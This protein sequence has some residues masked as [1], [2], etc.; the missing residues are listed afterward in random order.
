[1][2][3]ILVTNDFPPKT[4]GIQSYLW[5][6]W[7]R[8]PTDS[9]VVLT[10]RGPDRGAAAAKF[11][12]KEQYRIVRTD[13]A[14]LLPTP[15]LRRRINE[16]VKETAAVLVI[17][18]PV[19]PLGALG[20]G[21]GLDVPYGLVVHGA[22]TTMPGRF[23][24]SRHLMG[25]VLAGAKLVIAAGP[26]PA[27]QAQNAV[28]DH[29]LDT[30]VIPPGVDTAKFRPLVGEERDEARARFG[31]PEEARLV[32]SLSRLVPRKGMD[33]LIETSAELAK[34]RDDLVVAIGG[35]GRDRKRLEGLIQSFDA[36]V[37]LVGRVADEDLPAFYGCADVFAMLCRNRIGGLEEGFGIVFI[38]AASTGVA[39]VAGLSGGVPD[40]VV[41]GV[42]GLVVDRPADSR[43]A[44]GVLG[45]LLDD[46]AL[47]SRLGEAARERAVAE[48][49]LDNLAA[50]LSHAIE[51]AGG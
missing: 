21:R 5:E 23:P 31:L 7:R 37:R 29:S 12:Q 40:A 3:H 51:Q 14:V 24:G 11:D 39:Q 36:P 15:A 8:F 42:T 49:D 44:A 50:R 27:R 28:K 19:L 2:T 35:S 18:D 6:L 43:E 4:G 20:L 16:L 1:V 41:D 13:D 48:F 32:V 38:E 30:V 10:A 22:E 26:Y 46:P 33:V 45:K 47:R 9:A 34:E 25:R 17:I